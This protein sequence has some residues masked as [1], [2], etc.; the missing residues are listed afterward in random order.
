M[1]AEVKDLMLKTG[2]LCCI[3]SFFCKVPDCLSVTSVVDCCCCSNTCRC[4]CPTTCS[5][6]INQCCCIDCRSAFPCDFKKVPCTCGCLGIMCMDCASREAEAK[7]KD[8]GCDLTEYIP[9][10]NPEMKGFNVNNFE[11]EPLH[12]SVGQRTRV[13]TKDKDGNMFVIHLPLADDLWHFKQ[14]NKINN[15]SNSSPSPSKFSQVIPE[16]ER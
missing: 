15:G 10:F 13:F 16:A 9:G 3:C 7:G 6:C 2:C 12:F 8:T 5:T 1:A 4:G 14:L 11:T